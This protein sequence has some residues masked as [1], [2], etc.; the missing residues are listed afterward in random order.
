MRQDLCGPRVLTMEWI[1]GLRCTD[2]RAIVSSGIDVEEFIRGGVVTGLRQLL[3]VGRGT[4]LEP[5]QKSPADWLKYVIAALSIQLSSDCGKCASEVV[6]LLVR[7]CCLG[8]V[9]LSQ[10][11]DGLSGGGVHT[12][13]GL[14]VLLAAVAVV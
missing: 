1:D 5:L 14:A 9:S 6:L 11:P 8:V 12:W 4:R 3:E 10:L 7:A 2:P 13:P